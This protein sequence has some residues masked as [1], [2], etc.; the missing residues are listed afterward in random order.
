M[1]GSDGIDPQVRSGANRPGRQERSAE[2][3]TAKVLSE[4]L[5]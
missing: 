1:N 4:R 5:T 2:G 3:L